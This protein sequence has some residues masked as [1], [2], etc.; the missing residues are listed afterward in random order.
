MARIAEIRRKAQKKTNVLYDAWFTR[1]ISVFITAALAPL[2][3]PPNMVTVANLCVGLTACGLIAFGST[4]GVVVGICLV[5]LYA[6]LDSVDGEL[7]RLLGKTSLT[8]MFLEDL[9][10][11]AMINGFS[12][13]VGFYLLGT[14]Q[15]VLPLWIAVAFTAFGRNA[16]PCARRTLLQVLR[17][18]GESLSFSPASGSAGGGRGWMSRAVHLV[19]AHLLYHTNLRLVLTSLILVEILAGVAR[20]NL[21]L[22]AFYAYM[23]GLWLREFGLIVMVAASGFL[24]REISVISGAKDTGGQNQA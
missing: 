10:A 11:Y 5:H 16:M 3:V 14:T 18:P 7:A 23:G 8:G 20:W 12:L 9:S 19:D 1:Q 6:V 2:R 22:I 21:V 15:Q 24:R 4:A 17:N 13:A